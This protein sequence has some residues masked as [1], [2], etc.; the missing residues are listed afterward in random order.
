VSQ[1]TVNHPRVSEATKSRAPS[2]I[3][4]TGTAQRRAWEDKVLP[5]VEQVRPGLWSIPVPIPQSPLR[6]VLVYAFEL[7]AGIALIDA[8]WNAEESWEALNAGLAQMGCGPADVRSVLVTHIH[9]DHYGLAGRIREASGAWVG[10]HP[11]DAAL[12]TDRRGTAVGPLD[13]QREVLADCG[14]PHELLEPVSRSSLSGWDVGSRPV[15][16]VLIEDADVLDLPG[17]NLRAIWT[18]GHS[19][20]HLCFY[21]TERRLLFSGDHILPGIS[22]NISLH[23][24]RH[25]P[26]A[27]YLDALADLQLLDA[28]E[29]LPA[30][31]WRFRNLSR[32]ITELT[33]HHARR[34]AEAED[35]VAQAPGGT[36]HDL[37]RALTWSR[38]WEEF[39]GFMRRVAVNE[40]L[41]HLVLLREQQR[42]HEEPG[43]PRR[44]FPRCG[45]T[46]TAKSTA[47]S[48]AKT[49]IGT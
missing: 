23:H 7:S 48:T 13:R 44:W 5:A 3:E 2:G 27:D 45:V 34:L 33:A 17:W 32:R 1:P 22:P 8:G 29:V 38:P 41:A 4:V 43:P 26:L 28:D 25:N 35:L 37:A 15:P 16:D 31:Q 19:P 30:H 24:Q 12:L 46:G 18:P 9:P 39:N 10:L 36:P 6:Y 47:K 49:R 20:G 14:V 40:T 21:E 42:V 11:A